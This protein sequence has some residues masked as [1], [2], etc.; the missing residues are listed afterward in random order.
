MSRTVRLSV[1]LC[2]PPHAHR[3]SAADLFVLLFD[4]ILQNGADN[5]GH[6]LHGYYFAG[7][8]EASWRDIARAI[9]DALRA[10]G[11]TRDAEPTPFTDAELAQYFFSFVRRLAFL[12]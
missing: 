11:R 9:G 6:G 4:A 7:N 1:S 2:V 3:A 12:W 5:V 10:L 8:D